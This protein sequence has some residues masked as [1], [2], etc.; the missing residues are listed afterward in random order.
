VGRRSGGGFAP[1]P[2][3]SFKLEQHAS[4]HDND[5]AP[6][7]ALASVPI[8][9]VQHNVPR[10]MVQHARTGG[11]D[12]T[13]PERGRAPTPPALVPLAPAAR[14]K[15]VC[16][17]AANARSSARSCAGSLEQVQEISGFPWQLSILGLISLRRMGPANDQSYVMQASCNNWFVTT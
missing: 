2:K 1:T 9:K 16:R 8:C 5:F 14:D 3:Q 17:K 11:Y 13:G 6:A 10:S 7:Y 15:I 12:L 4:G